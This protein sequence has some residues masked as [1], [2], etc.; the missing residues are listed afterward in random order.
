MY[1]LTDLLQLAVNE[2]AEELQLATGKA[3]VII[4]RGQLRTLDLPELATDNVAELF[5]SFASSEQ[6][7]E[8]RRCGDTRFNYVSPSFGRFAVKASAER[9]RFT[10]I[11]KPL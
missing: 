5:S 10:L 2:S 3:P 9:E 11:M 7:E 8:L 1:C 4:V 6:A